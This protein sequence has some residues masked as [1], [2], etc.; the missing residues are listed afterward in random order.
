LL[1]TRNVWS[2]LFVKLLWCIYLSSSG[3]S[4]KCLH[5]QILLCSWKGKKKKKEASFCS[6]HFDMQ[7]IVIQT[8]FH[9]II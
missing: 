9:T 6:C 4:W 5:C 8:I 1:N 3:L 7:I 2:P